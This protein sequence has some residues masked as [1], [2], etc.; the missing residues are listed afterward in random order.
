LF[1][2]APLVGSSKHSHRIPLQERRSDSRHNLQSDTESFRSNLAVE[3]HRQNTVFSRLHER[4]AET[5]ADVYRLLS[6]AETSVRSM[7]AP[8]QPIG[9]APADEKM[10]KSAKTPGELQTKFDAVRIW[11][12]ASTCETADAVLTELRQIHNHFNIV[13]RERTPQGEG[14]A[15]P[16]EWSKTWQRVEQDIP[17]LKSALENDFREILGVTGEAR[18]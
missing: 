16:T 3:A 4:R 9:E 6:A 13:V 15:N 14:K 2:W 7:V 11:F 5:I 1:F 12:K 10:A 18:A 17:A 8:F